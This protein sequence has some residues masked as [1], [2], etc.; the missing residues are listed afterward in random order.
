MRTG[1]VTAFFKV[2]ALEPRGALAVYDVH[3]GGVVSKNGV[4]TTISMQTT[5]HVRSKLS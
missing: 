2:I 1:S 4:A 3:E 5:K